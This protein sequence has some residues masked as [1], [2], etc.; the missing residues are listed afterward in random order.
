MTLDL[1]LTSADALEPW[2]VALANVGAMPGWDAAQVQR[3]GLQAEQ[4]MFAATGGVNTHKGAIFSLGWLCVMAADLGADR[5]ID[6]LTGAVGSIL[7]PEVAA[8]RIAALQRPN[9]NADTIANTRPSAIPEATKHARVNADKLEPPT[10]GERA[11]ALHGLAG[12]RGEAASGF[13]TVRQWGLPSYRAALADGMN[14]DDALLAAL[15]SLMAHNDDTNLVARGGLAALQHVQH[16]AAELEVTQPSAETR[17]AALVAADQDFSSRGW[18]PGG[19]ADLL[20]LTWW[21]DSWANS[22]A[23]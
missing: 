22:R 1:L 23:V 13:A 17:R 12:A 19:S 21:L 20:A 14:V 4:A 6:A 5:S 18:S 8:W 11:L 7:A 15:V 16:W 3:L 2:F 10:H 9:T